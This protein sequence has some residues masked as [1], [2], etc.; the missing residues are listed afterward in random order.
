[1]AAEDT[2]TRGRVIG[3]D[4]VQFAIPHGSEN[5]ARL[6]YGG[7]LGLEELP[8]PAHL[9][10]NGGCWFRGGAANIH[11]GVEQGFQP[12]RKAHAALLVDDLDA[13]VL[14][15]QASGFDFK[16]GKPIDGY[17]RGDIRDPFGNRIELM[18]RE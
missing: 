9:A 6:F 8:K 15:L 1:M 12:A 7:L 16:P 18:E 4:H 2:T 11:L 3:L 5:E 14:R 10:V 17:K 13:L